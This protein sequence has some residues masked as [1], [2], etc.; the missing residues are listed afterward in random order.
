MGGLGVTSVACR[1]RAGPTLQV[2]HIGSPAVQENQDRVPVLGIGGLF[3][4][5]IKH[6]GFQSQPV[7]PARLLPGIG[8][9]PRIVARSPSNQCGS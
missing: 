5:K 9:W 2:S 4:K 8:D 3:H 6:S 7:D 1:G